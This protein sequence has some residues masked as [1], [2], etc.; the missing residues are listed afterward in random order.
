VSRAFVMVLA[1]PDDESFF[2]AGTIAKSVAAG[3]RVGLICATRGERGATCDL[4]PIEELP[5]IREAE[6][7]DAAR[8]LGIHELEF[9]PYQDQQLAKAPMDDVRR[10]VVR[11]IRRMRPQT[12]FTFDPDGANQHTDHVAISRFA[13]DGIAAAA[14]PRWYPDEGE[15]CQVERVLWPST[16][17]VWELNEGA[18]DRPGV[19]YL[20]NIDEF[21]SVKESALRAHRTQ[22]RGLSKL[23]LS[24]PTGMSWEAFRVAAGTRPTPVPSGLVV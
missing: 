9:L 20:I 5:R 4:C 19:D 1:H 14:D 13:M 22:W 10:S 17:R 12:V 18:A 16:V 7:R 24:N 11:M 15:A 6:L 21:R 8:I 3:V 2:A 23:F